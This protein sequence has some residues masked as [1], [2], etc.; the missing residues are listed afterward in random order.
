MLVRVS[1]LPV[2][3]AGRGEPAL[4]DAILVKLCE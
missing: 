3:G 4:L 2:T 1:A